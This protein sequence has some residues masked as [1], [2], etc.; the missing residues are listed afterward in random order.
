MAL[1]P[2]TLIRAGSDAYGQFGQAQKP[3]TTIGDNLFSWTRGDTIAAPRNTLKA[4][5]SMSMSWKLQRRTPIAARPIARRKGMIQRISMVQIVAM[6][7]SP[8]GIISI[9]S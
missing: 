4:A 3:R 5:A 7:R 2:L 6:R 1:L 9:T 8:M